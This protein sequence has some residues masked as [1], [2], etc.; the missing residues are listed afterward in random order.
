[1]CTDDTTYGQVVAREAR[2]EVH[3]LL[4]KILVPEDARRLIW[5]SV[6][7]DVT[8]VIMRF[9]IM[10]YGVDKL[11]E[12]DPELQY[13]ADLIKLVRESEFSEEL[14]ECLYDCLTAVA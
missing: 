4:E 7:Q 1:M 3:E 6:S 14:R 5:F 11:W 10:V 8:A 9:M 13:Y 2:Q 12:N